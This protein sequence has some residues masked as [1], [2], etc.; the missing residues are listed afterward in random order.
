MLATVGLG[1]VIALTV[2]ARAR[3]LAIRAALGADARRL[4]GL[5]IREAAILTAAGVVLGALGAIALGRGVAPV[6]I[7]VRPDDPWTLVAVGALA[8]AAGLLT[9]WLPARRAARTNAVDALKAE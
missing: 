6:L 3:E 5:V 9:A 4:R 2:S 1:S 8:A 7:G